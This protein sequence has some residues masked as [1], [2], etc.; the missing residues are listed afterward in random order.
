MLTDTDDL[1]LCELCPT[2]SRFE[3]MHMHGDIH[4]CDACDKSWREHFAKC[5]HVWFPTLNEFCDEV[6]ECGRC[7]G[8]VHDEDFPS[9]VGAQAPPRAKVN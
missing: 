9:V 8:Q 5:D 1:T 3:D 6:H 7:G 4:V 2:R